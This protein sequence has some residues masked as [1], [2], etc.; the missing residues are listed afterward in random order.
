MT[1]PSAHSVFFK[2]AL[3]SSSFL[4]MTIYASIPAFAWHN[5]EG[6]EMWAA[7]LEV[8]QLLKILSQNL[9]TA[10]FA[11][12]VLG[13]DEFET[14]KYCQTQIWYEELSVSLMQPSASPSSRSTSFLAI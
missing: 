8:Q 5:T 10:I 7:A 9:Q 2:I 14:V 12:A 6:P 3:L 11:P 13:S 4:L 1:L